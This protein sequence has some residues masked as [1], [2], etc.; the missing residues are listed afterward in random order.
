MSTTS[1]QVY[2]CILITNATEIPIQVFTGKGQAIFYL[3]SFQGQLK[4]L[5]I[6]VTFYLI[7]WLHE[8]KELQT[9]NFEFQTRKQFRY[10]EKIHRNIQQ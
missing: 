2:I 4:Q 1:T 5:Q 6:C 10:S 7:K 3:I 8:K 9:R